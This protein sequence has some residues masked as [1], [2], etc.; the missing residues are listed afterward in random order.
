M[1][2]VARTL[3]AGT[4]TG[5]Q[6]YLAAK[7]S[8][9]G[10]IAPFVPF[11]FAF[12]IIGMIMSVLIVTNVVSGS[13]VAGY[14]RIGIL[15]SIGFTPGQVLAAYTG[16]VAVPAVAGCLGGV[17]LGN[18]LAQPVLP[19]PP[20]VRSRLAGGTGLGRTCAFPQ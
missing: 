12:G 10:N 5:T 3:P 4:V 16:Q 9:T 13:V 7:A 14:R 20:G 18:L 8:E 1:A 19:R 11:L 2:A 15:K 17:L 6:S